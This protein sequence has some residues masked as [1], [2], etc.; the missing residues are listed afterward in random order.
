MSTARAPGHV[1]LATP[2]DA[3]AVAAIYAPIV[4]ATTI[5]FETEPPPPA[6]MAERIQETLTRYPWIVCEN[7]RGI[8]GYA[9]ATAHRSRTAYQWAVEVS[10]YVGAS[11]QRRGIGRRLYSAL[12]RLLVQQGFV[13][14]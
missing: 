1:R 14:A 13:H 3:A 5:S 7:E 4:G 8:Q 6:V 2:A 10:V 12:L 9:Y 11:S